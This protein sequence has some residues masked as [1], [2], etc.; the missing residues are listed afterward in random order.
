[1]TK[2]PVIQRGGTRAAQGEPT[3]FK[4]E[5]GIP[6]PSPMA[7]LASQYPFE[8][9]KPT[10]S[11]LVECKTEDRSR[12]LNN[13]STA[14]RNWKTRTKNVTWVFRARQVD[15]GVRVWRDK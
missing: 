9:M 1:M 12:T 11:F 15:E 3:K 13:L 8:D 2:T 7:K 4:I 14:A 6:L 5:K 10:D